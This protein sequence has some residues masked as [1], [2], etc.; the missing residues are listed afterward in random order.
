M[1]KL[2]VTV[3][4]V[5]QML[6]VCRNRVYELIYSGQLASVKMGRSRRIAVDELK[7]FVAASTEAAA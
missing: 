7:R 1:E 3:A 5:A 4:E 6:G 2:M